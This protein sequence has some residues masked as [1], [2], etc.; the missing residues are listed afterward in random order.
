MFPSSA[1]KVSW[2]KIIF[3]SYLY[4][5]NIFTWTHF[6]VANEKHSFF[7]KVKYFSVTGRHLPAFR[8]QPK[9]R[10]VIRFLHCGFWQKNSIKLLKYLSKELTNRDCS[11]FFLLQLLYLV[12]NKLLIATT[13]QSSCNFQKNNFLLILFHQFKPISSFLHYPS[14]AFWLICKT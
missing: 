2:L 1:G 9:M 5:E 13:M 6:P 4:P 7:E 14:K 8:L 3:P 10:T 11:F 12:C